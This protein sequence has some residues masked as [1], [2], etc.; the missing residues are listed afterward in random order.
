MKLNDFNISQGLT[1]DDV[2]LMPK[3]SDIESRSEENISLSNNLGDVELSIPIISSPMDTITEAEMVDAMDAHGGLGVVHRF[4]TI[5]EQKR[6]VLDSRAKAAA[7]GMTGDYLERALVLVASGVKILCIDTAHGHHATMKICI[8]N[9]RQE[10]GDS[11]HIM[12]GS[13][14]TYDGAAALI[15]WG[16]DSLRV[17]IGGG[18]ICS[19][20]LQTGFGVPNLTALM[21]AALAK[22]TQNVDREIKIIADGGIRKSGDMVKALAAG[23]D[24]IM[25]GSMIAG[26]SETPGEL[27]DAPGLNKIYRGMASR[28]AQHDWRGTASAPEGVSKVI[29]YKGPVSSVLGPVP[30]WIRSGLSYCGAR[31]VKELQERAEFFQQ[32]AAGVLEG[33]THIDYAK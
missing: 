12:A 22:R 8:E 20:R 30:A 15:Q 6:I 14:A 27:I 32:T 18:S 7:I 11:V 3:F 29:P 1:Y 25:L 33:Q 21:L 10:F 24:F 31:N 16:A 9:L 4:N 5:E 28:E 17:G 13:I 23:A 19:T 2:T 26:T